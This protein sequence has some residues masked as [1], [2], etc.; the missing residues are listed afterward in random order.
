VT[1]GGVG[2]AQAIKKAG[3]A[4]MPSTGRPLGRLASD[5]LRLVVD[6]GLLQYGE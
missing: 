3:G 2:G 4:P 1:W 6:K 5:D